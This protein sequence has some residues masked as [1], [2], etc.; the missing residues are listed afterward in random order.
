[1]MDK[2]YS[3]D[4]VFYATLSNGEVESFIQ[5]NNYSV[6][7]VTNGHRIYLDSVYKINAYDSIFSYYKDIRLEEDVRILRLRDYINAFFESKDLVFS[8]S[9]L[10]HKRYGVVL[11]ARAKALKDAYLDQQSYTESRGFYLD[12]YVSKLLQEQKVSEKEAIYISQKIQQVQK[13]R[14]ESDKGLNIV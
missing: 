3:L 6:D 9:S 4:K 11:K 1:M 10:L 14:L 2:K 7:N 13:Q 12:E 5:G 8:R